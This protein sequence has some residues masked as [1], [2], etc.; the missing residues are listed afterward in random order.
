LTQRVSRP[1]ARLVAAYLARMRE[2]WEVTSRAP[3]AVDEGGPK[4]QLIGVIRAVGRFLCR[5]VRAAVVMDVVS[6]PSGLV[7]RLR[8]CRGAKA[9]QSGSQSGS[10]SPQP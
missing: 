10:H 9:T 5:R 8:R 1:L 2:I 6:S 4:A 7:R 3:L